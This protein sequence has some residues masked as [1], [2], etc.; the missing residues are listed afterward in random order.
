MPGETPVLAVLPFHCAGD[1]ADVLLARGLVEDISGELT[2]FRAFSVVSPVSAATVAEL[3]DRDAG[4]T[5]V[6]WRI[7]HAI[8][9]IEAAHPVLGRHLANSLRTGTFCSYQPERPVAWR[10]AAR[11]DSHPRAAVPAK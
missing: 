10:L 3:P 1:E 7:R 9:K 2:R 11:D 6:T 5:A 4:G 8:R